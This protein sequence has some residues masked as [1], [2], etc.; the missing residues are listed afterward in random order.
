MIVEEHTMYFK[1]KGLCCTKA[2]QIKY[3][4][5]NVAREKCDNDEKCIYVFDADGDGNLFTYCREGT[6]TFAEDFGSTIWAK[7]SNE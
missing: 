5:F 4:S 7:G 2:L 3:T 1:Q 6:V